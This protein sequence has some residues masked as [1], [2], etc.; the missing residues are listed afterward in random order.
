MTT[1]QEFAEQLRAHR[2]HMDALPVAMAMARDFATGEGVLTSEVVQTLI[3][4]I[5]R[6]TAREKQLQQD[7]REEQRAFQQEAREIA[8]EAAWNERERHHQDGGF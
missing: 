7:M 6:L 5:E 4:E 2:A 1:P 8:A 3:H